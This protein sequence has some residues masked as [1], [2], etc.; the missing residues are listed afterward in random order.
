MAYVDLEIRI[1]ERQDK[2]YPVD[3]TLAE[4]QEFPRG[5]L[6]P[7]LLPWASTG[8]SDEDGERLFSWLFAD[9]LLKTNWDEVRGQYRNRR[10]RLWIDAYAPEL[11]T[12]PWE[13]LRDPGDN[14]VPLNVAAAV[15][16]PFSRYLA[17]KWSP[18]PPIQ[19]RPIKILVVIANPDNLSKYGLSSI[20]V[21]DEWS[22]IEK[23]TA[24]LDVRLIQLPEPCT[25]SAV[26]KA[27]K[28]GYHILH[29]VGHG[30]YSERREQAA[31]YLADQMN[32][33]KPVNSQAFVE[34]LTRQLSE[35]VLEEDDGLRLIPCFCA[36]LASF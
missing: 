34:M 19:K 17:H 14:D 10:I 20:N 29:F 9:D 36:K 5:Y 33:A 35:T 2:G 8:N 24:S 6:N 31:I 3:M 16:T 30:M 1:L 18:S 28:D 13:S 25:L 15:M 21:D 7:E 27:L 26:E 23:A 11:H 22:I 32:Q 12:I 4:K